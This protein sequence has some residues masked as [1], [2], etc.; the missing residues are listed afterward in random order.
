ME[1]PKRKKNRL[2][3]FSYSSENGY[4]LTLCTAK[5]KQMFW[6]EDGLS[7]L[8]LYLESCLL[9]IPEVYPNA[10]LDKYS[11]MP[12]HVHLILILQGEDCGCA[13]VSQI[14]GQ[15]KRLVSKRAGASIWQKSYYDHVI[16]NE[17]DYREIWKY[18]EGNP[19]TWREKHK[20]QCL[21]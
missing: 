10:V 3:N 17:S 16:R 8:G 11:I 4:F 6:N 9:K 13:D 21:L 12:D 14:I 1:Y 15:L 7:G 18:I 19:S 20:N 5:R 2:E